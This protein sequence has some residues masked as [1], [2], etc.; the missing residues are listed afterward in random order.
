MTNRLIYFLNKELRFTFCL[1]QN[2]VF[3]V[4]ENTRKRQFAY[5]DLTPCLYAVLTAFVARA[6]FP[7]VISLRSFHVGEVY[8]C[9][10]F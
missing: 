6:L 4:L 1:Q 10:L 3:T 7:C 2:H 8:Q 5:F 9:I